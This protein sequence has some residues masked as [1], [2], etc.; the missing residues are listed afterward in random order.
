MYDKEGGYTMR[1]L[2]KAEYDQIHDDYKG[3]YVDFLGLRP[4]MKGRRVAML[5]GEGTTLSIEGV[6]FLVDGDYSHLPLLRK[7]NAEEGACY[8]IAGGF[9]QVHRIYR[10]TAEDARSRHLM[11]LDRAE[12]S[13]GDFALIGSDH[14]NPWPV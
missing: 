1:I 9:A 13:A 14:I 7:E 12:T 8:Q 2:S 3:T 10:L 11:Y 5:P 6:H 4:R